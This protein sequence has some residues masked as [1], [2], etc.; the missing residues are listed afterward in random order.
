M[1]TNTWSNVVLRRDDALSRYENVQPPVNASHV[2]HLR[3]RKPCRIAS[4]TVQRSY[5]FINDG[6]ITRF[7]LNSYQDTCECCT[8]NQNLSNVSQ[9]HRKALVVQR[10]LLS[11]IPIHCYEWIQDREM[12]SRKEKPNLIY[13]EHGIYPVIHNR[14]W[15]S[16]VESRSVPFVFSPV[17]LPF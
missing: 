14:L 15:N 2:S 10:R 8:W 7:A 11:C 1:A 5:F 13:M 9:Q 6:R 17:K 4:N 3:F 16:I 12:G